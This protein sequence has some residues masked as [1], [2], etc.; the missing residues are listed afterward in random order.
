A[1]LGGDPGGERWCLPCGPGNTGSC[2]GPGICCG[3]ELGCYLGTAEARRCAE[4]DAL[5]SPCQAGGEPCGSGGRCAANGICCTAESCSTDSS[6][7][8]EGSEGAREA[9][10]EKSLAVLD[11][12]AGDLLL[13]LMHL[14]NR[15]QQGKH[16]LL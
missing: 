14:A 16:P 15:Q 7:L 10:D 6:C 12:S 11:G 2:F 9:A 3:P 1:A 5:P 8:D 4:E 13:K